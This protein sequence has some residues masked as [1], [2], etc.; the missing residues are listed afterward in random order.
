MS[1]LNHRFLPTSGAKYCHICHK[2]VSDAIHSDMPVPALDEPTDLMPRAT[3]DNHDTEDLQQGDFVYL[4]AGSLK[5]TMYAGC[6]T[7]A[8]AKIHRFIGNLL[9]QR[10]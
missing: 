5:F 7:D 1:L 8:L 10:S 4:D 6:S 3:D 9:A 2:A